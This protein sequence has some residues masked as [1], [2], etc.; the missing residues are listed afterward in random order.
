VGF[1]HGLRTD[2]TIA[3]P[4]GAEA[5]F[6]YCDETEETTTKYR[7]CA[8][9]AAQGNLLI[10]VGTAGHITSRST[11]DDLRAVVSRA[12]QRLVAASK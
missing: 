2:F 4:D 10:E 9:L 8:A 5:F 7:Y 3:K 6:T 12:V 11:L 1:E